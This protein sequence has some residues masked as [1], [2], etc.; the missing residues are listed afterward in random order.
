M[1]RAVLSAGVQ[2]AQL[3]AR[4]GLAHTVALHTPALSLLVGRHAPS[5]RPM[6]STSDYL[7]PRGFSSAAEA[8]LAEATAAPTKTFDQGYVAPHKGLQP[9]TAEAYF[10]MQPVYS[11]EYVES[12]KPKHLPAEKVYQRIAYGAIQTVR[13]TFDKVTGYGPQMTEAK[14]LQRII[15]LETVAGVPG[16]VAGMLRHMGSL[17]SMRRDHGWIHTLLEEAE[18][19]RMHLLTFLK[20]RQPGPVFRAMVIVAQ[21]VFF[22]AYFV[23]YLIS[24]KTC[25][26]LVGY[27]EEEAVKTYTHCLEDLDKGKIP[28]WKDKQAPPLAKVYWKLKDDATMRDLILAVRADEACH[29]H[30]NHTFSRMKTTDDNPFTVGSHMVP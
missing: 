6:T 15:F 25:H 20:I 3:S 22:N 19:E 29:S 13:W 10:L 4:A 11:Q 30:V 16:M 5:A 18:N 12:V 7:R 17:R 8:A 21:G 14:W 24:P 28:E 1:L 27:L 26:A 9:T 23:A 2:A